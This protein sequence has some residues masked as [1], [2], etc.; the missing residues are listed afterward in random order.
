[1]KKLPIFLLLLAAQLILS[2]QVKSKLKGKVTDINGLDLPFVNLTLS[3][4]QGESLQTTSDF[5]GFYIFH[6]LDSGIWNLKASLVGYQTKE[7]KGFKIAPAKTM[8]LNLALN[9]GTQLRTVEVIGYKK[10]LVALDQSRSTS[11]Q[12]IE[13]MAVRSA[14]DIAKTAGNGVVTRGGRAQGNVTYVDGIKVIGST[15]LPKSAIQEVKVHPPGVPAMYESDVAFEQSEYVIHS[16]PQGSYTSSRRKRKKEKFLNYEEPPVVRLYENELY[17]EIADNPFESPRKTPLSTFSIDVDKAA[18]ANVR[19]FLNQGMLPPTNA[20]RIEELINYFDYDYPEPT[21][22]HPFSITTE[23]ASNPWNA[24]R[25]IAMIGLQ[26]KTIEMDEAPKSNLV[27]LIDVSGSMSSYNKL[28]L[29]KKGLNLLVDKMRPEDQVAIVVYAGAAGVVLE[30]TSG[31]E[32]QKIKATLNR[33]SAGGSTAGGAG[34]HLAY[35]IA[36]ENFIKEGNNRIILATDG[37]FNVGTSSQEALV[38]L[39][40]EKRE[41]DIFLSV[42][43]F[44]NGNLQDYKMEQ[45]ANKGN[46]NYNYIDNIIE[47][48]KVLVKEMG[49]TLVAI[50]KD[51]KVQAEFNPAKVKAYRLIGYV[52]RALADEDFNDDRKDAGELGSGHSVTV[53]YEIIP[54][55]SMEKIMDVDSLKYQKVE[56][57]KTAFNDEILTVKFRYKQPDGDVSTLM[58]KVLKDERKALEDASVNLRF[59][60]AVASFGM[61]LRGSESVKDFS[62]E[63]ID[64]IARTA[65]GKDPEGY[66]AEF[67]KMV[68]TAELLDQRN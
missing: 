51:V 21:D 47:A 30:S 65:K 49:G 25:Q 15:S 38:K 62:Y 7:L 3:N 52:N 26:G 8:V 4:A 40:E 10:P 60:A 42:L 39:I 5:S 66:R 43:G 14:P 55:N 45:L 37:D 34:I 19:R 48:K 54:A 1:M 17:Q 63:D 61:K 68:E 22:E 20:V 44:G 27:F 59:S 53:L 58:T 67:L 64:S 13:R 9:T 36:K 18:Y 33:L 41:S 29:L 32:K 31:K 11:R 6:H 28:E 24:E 12:D 50:A 2:A 35:E 56:A 23:L 46:G 16:P 57:P